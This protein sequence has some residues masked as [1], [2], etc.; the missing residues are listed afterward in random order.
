M[1]SRDHDQSTTSGKGTLTLAAPTL[2]QALEAVTVAARVE[3]AHALSVG[4]EEVGTL[5]EEMASARRQH[6]LSLQQV[7]DAANITKSHAWEIEQGRSRN[8][9]IS[10][11]WALSGALGLPFVRLAMAALNTVDARDGASSRPTVADSEESRE[12]P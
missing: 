9:T 2:A 5:G 7:A 12:E 10:T 4:R 3:V 11:V 8:P 6:G 1:A